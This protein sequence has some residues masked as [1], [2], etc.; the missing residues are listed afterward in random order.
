MGEGDFSPCPL[1]CQLFYQ[2]QNCNDKIDDCGNKIDCACLLVFLIAAFLMRFLAQCFCPPFLILIIPYTYV[3]VNSFLKKCK[4]IGMIL[5][6][7]SWLNRIEHLTSDQR[8]RG[9]IPLEC[10][11][12][13]TIRYG[14][15]I[16]NWTEKIS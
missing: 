6:L 3:Y 8:V 9:S 11:T 14:W 16:L 15:A 7:H 1:P 13:I 4:K 12:I 10:A 2:K 5:V